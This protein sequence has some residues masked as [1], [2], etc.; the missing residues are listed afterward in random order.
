MPLVVGAAAAPEPPGAGL[1]APAAQLGGA[2]AGAAAT[3][4]AAEPP[5]AGLAAPAAQPG[6]ATAG[7]AAAAAAGGAGRGCDGSRSGGGWKGIS[8]VVV[9]QPWLTQILMPDTGQ[10]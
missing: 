5:G 6:G 7:A 8:T 4:A 9:W 10:R 2:T 1:V 3:A